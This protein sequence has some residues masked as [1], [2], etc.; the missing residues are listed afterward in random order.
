MAFN[1]SR[2]VHHI[3]TISQCIRLSRHCLR[4]CFN[5]NCI[6]DKIHREIR[7]RFLHLILNRCKWSDISNN[8]LY[9]FRVHLSVMLIWH[10]GKHCAAF[11][12]NARCY[13]SKKFA[14]CVASNAGGRNVSWII[15]S[16]ETNG[17]IK[18]LAAFPKCAFNNRPS[19][20]IPIACGMAIDAYSNAVGKISSSLNSRRRIF[21]SKRRGWA[22]VRKR[23]FY[24]D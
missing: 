13:Q 9:I 17:L 2:C 24:I 14:I 16:G 20:F 15:Y 6:D 18:T 3:F 11:F 19:K 7:N 21:N 12:C 5:R 22:Y 10:H 1:T 23:N 8:A 4:I